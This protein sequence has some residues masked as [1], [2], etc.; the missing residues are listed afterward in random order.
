MPIT[1]WII[2]KIIL[3]IIGFILVVSLLQF[4]MSIHPPRYYD[5]DTPN[6]YGLKYE[7]V[8]FTTSDKIK[9]KAWL[10]GSEKAK[11]TVI[12]GHGYPFNKGN[13]LST[14][15]FLYPDYNLLLYDHRYFGESDG[16]ITTVGIKEVEDVKAAVN[17][18][19]KK[20]GKEK[21][22]A[23]YGFSLSASAMLMSKTEVNAIIADSPYSDLDTMIN[24][25]YRI[26]GPLKFPFVKFTGLL[27]LIFFR[28]HPK[29]VSPA[30]SIKNTSIPIMVIHGK[31]DTQIP[32]DNAY[33]IKASNPNIELWIVPNAD[34]GEAHALFKKEYEI[35]INSFLE[36][37]M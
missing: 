26:F 8:T 34:H 27:S 31:E 25:I 11:G 21:P 16:F 37:Y 17:F 6:N 23:L 22:I 18:V 20:F 33:L 19:H 14:T 36:K 32:I 15:K 35:R 2:S 29:S 12:V 30:L 4:F 28:T 1:L 13:I 5:P 3:T 24:H 7:N 9:I 10:I